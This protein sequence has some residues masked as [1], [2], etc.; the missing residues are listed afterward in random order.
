MSTLP[1]GFSTLILPFAC[2]FSK[3]VFESVQVLL[4]GAILAP[5]KR[6]VT[7]VLGIMGLSQERHV[8]TCHRILNRSAWSS[9]A[10]S[11]IWPGLLVCAFASV[12]PL[13][14]ALDDTIERRWGERIAARHLL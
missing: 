11:R 2:L 5:G 12:G 9:L 4:A 13:V 6:A 3:R 10:A 8:Q 1:A 7:S 14:F